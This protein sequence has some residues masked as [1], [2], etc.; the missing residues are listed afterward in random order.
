[1]LVEVLVGIRLRGILVVEAEEQ[2]DFYK[3]T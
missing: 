1:L 3:V 2:E